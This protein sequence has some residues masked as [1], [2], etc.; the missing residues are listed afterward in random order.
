MEFLHLA[1]CRLP[2]LKE[3]KLVLQNAAVSTALD[4]SRA[5]FLQNHPTIEVLHWL[6][7]GMPQ[8]SS[9]A[10]PNLKSLRSNRQLIMAVNVPS[11]SSSQAAASLVTPPST[12][13][14]N[15]IPVPADVE[16]TVASPIIR[17]KIENLDIYSLDAHTL[18]ELK[19]IDPSTLRRLKLSSFD[20]LDT[21]REIGDTFPN[22]EWLLLPSMYMPPDSLYPIPVSKVYFSSV[23]LLVNQITHTSTKA[24]WLEILPIFP[25]LE[26]F[27]GL[28]IWQSVS[29]DKD[30]MHQ[31][32]LALVQSCPKLRILDRAD[33]Y[34]NWD[35]LKEIVITRTGE[36]EEHINYGIVR[37]PNRSVIALYHQKS[38]NS[39]LRIG[40]L[41]T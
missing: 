30:E 18:L 26:T 25:K 17:R 20:G 11:L 24:M 22:I 1:E 5:L 8:L 7:L 38:Y 9:D 6:P 37:K 41:L 23:V 3:L 2:K 16:P 39:H 40:N 27:R 28:G 29:H 19:C 31:V 12:P 21:L 15:T 4:R 10:L 34:Q 14:A 35:P 32:I 33:K 36:Y 13:L